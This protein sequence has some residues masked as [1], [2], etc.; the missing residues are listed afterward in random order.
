M[1]SGD[2]KTVCFFNST[3]AWGGGEK[4]HYDMAAGIDRERW[5]PMVV[6]GTGS[7]LFRRSS[8][9]VLPVYNI[10]VSNLSF[11]NPVK[12]LHVKDIFRGG[13]VWTVIINHPADLK[14]A[15]PAARL[16]GVPNIVYRRGSAIPVM[17]TALNRHIFAK[18]ITDII[19]NSEETRSSITRNNPLLF[20]SARIRVIYNGLDIEEWDARTA[21]SIYRHHPGELVIGNAGRLERQKGQKHLMKIAAALRE[22]GLSFRLLI[23]GEGSLRQD[24]ERQAESL[25]VSDIVTFTGFVENMKSFMSSIDIF[26]LTS[27]WEGFG[28]VLVEA[29][30]SGIPVVAFDTSSNPEIVEEGVSGYLADPFD[31]DQAAERIMALASD[32]ALRERIGAAGR[33]SAAE[34][35]SLAASIGRFES[36]LSS[37]SG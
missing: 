36:F 29:M 12:I 24:L 8:R 23:A 5:R 9:A 10:S 31:T 11:L 32:R 13:K 37:L 33:R 18:Y 22:R 14:L 27:L 3:R 16:A 2:R 28:Y 17:D 20:D 19:T 1:G 15:G 4:W 30:A 35:F 26:V 34:R 6:A 21:E 7:E 25:G